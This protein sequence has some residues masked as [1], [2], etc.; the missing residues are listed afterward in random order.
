MVANM[1]FKKIKSIAPN[2]DV[3]RADAS[4]YSFVIIHE[5]ESGHGFKNYTGFTATYKDQ[6]KPKYQ[7]TTRINTKALATFEEAKKACEQQLLKLD[8]LQ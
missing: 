3:F 4:H 7:T 8:K 1:N 5:K 2:M 6:R